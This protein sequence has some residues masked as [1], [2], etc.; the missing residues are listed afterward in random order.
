MLSLSL[1]SSNLDFAL[2]LLSVS[3]I[4]DSL[5]SHCFVVTHNSG[6]TVCECQQW[7]GRCVTAFIPTRRRTLTSNRLDV[8][9]RRRVGEEAAIRRMSN[10]LVDW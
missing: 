6:N 4:L 9:A 5:L 10:G 8:N 1:F 3:L 2:P 7:N